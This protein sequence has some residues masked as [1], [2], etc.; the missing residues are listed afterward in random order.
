MTRFAFVTPAFPSHMRALQSVARELVERGH[1]ATFFHQSDAAALLD[2]P[3]IGFE[4]VGAATH[5]AGSLA[6]TLQ[7][8]ARPGGPRGLRRVIQDVASATDMLCRALPDALSRV[9]VDAVVSDQ[10][11]AA[12]GLVAEALGLPYVS[13]A[14]ALPVNREPGVPLPVMPWRFADD[15]RARQRYA[16]SRRVYDHLMAPHAHVIAHHAAV[17]GLT[18]REALHDCLSPYAQISQTVADFEFPRRDLPAHFHHVG[19]LRDR[20]PDPPLEIALSQDRPVVFASLGTL[21][22]QRL[23]VFR[24]V[25]RA[26][27]RLDV[28]L[29]I[30]HCGGL[31]EAQARSLEAPGAVWVT[32]FAPQR[33]M[34]ARADAVVSHAGLNTVLDACAAGTPI[35]ALPIAFDQ[36]GVAARVVHAGAG[37]KASARWAT[38]KQ[39]QRGLAQLLEDPG[40]R[41]RAEA[42]GASVAAAGGAARAADIVELA[43]ATARPVLGRAA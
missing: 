22:G 10:M 38:A 42:L 19:P 1:T 15:A 14:C 4:A 21:Q 31:T 43:A 32:D 2:A 27:R 29:V 30:A 35:L 11:E 36:P 23:S 25:A 28:Q 5:P 8:A 39:L 40:F 20:A 41:L 9:G 13:V 16:G 24:R 33:A 3:G 26:C 6:G 34:L 18:P 12:G 37:L 17:F 7:R